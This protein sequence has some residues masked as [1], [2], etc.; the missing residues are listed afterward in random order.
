MSITI[1]DMAPI[2]LCV[3]TQELFD[4]RRFQLN[5]CDHMLLRVKDR[6]AEEHLWP[7]KRAINSESA[8]KRFLEG[9]KAVIISNID[10]I[11]SLSTSRYSSLNVKSIEKIRKDALDLIKQVIYSETFEQIASL[12]PDF[13]TKI[14]LP[15][16]EMFLE[17]SK[18]L[19]L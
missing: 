8:T 10:K 18:R 16:Y 15:V 11:L 14:T 3:A 19:R 2:G 9:H 17:Y 1:A 5:F 7:L 4:A 6:V 12:E 13:K